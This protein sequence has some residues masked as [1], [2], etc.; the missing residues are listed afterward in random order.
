MAKLTVNNYDEL[1]ARL[2]EK[3]G[4]S[5]WLLVDQERINLRSLEVRSL[6]LTVFFLLQNDKNLKLFDKYACQ[7]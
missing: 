2:G 4:E 3:L 1:A 5:E 6:I 7:K